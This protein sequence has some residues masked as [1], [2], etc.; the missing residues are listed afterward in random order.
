MPRLQRRSTGEDSLAEAID[1]LTRD[2]A[3]AATVEP[4]SDLSLPAARY[5]RKR[6]GDWPRSTRLA[7]VSEMASLGE[8]D[9]RF[10]FER[11]L[12]VALSDED[13]DVRLAAV[14]ALWE[15]E[16]TALLNEL[17][18]R[19][20]V[21]TETRVRRSLLRT[22]GRFARLAVEGRLD[23]DQRRRIEE[24]LVDAALRDS[25]EDIQLEAMVAVAYLQPVAI[26]SQIEDAYDQGHD[27][28]REQALRAMGRFGGQQWS[29]RV[30]DALRAGDSDQRVEAARAAPYVEDRRVVPYLYEAAED[31]E[32]PDIQF[33]ALRALGEIGGPEI[34]S[35]LEEM[36]DSTS[37]DVSQ[38]ADNALGNASLLDGT[39][40]GIPT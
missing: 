28:A 1:T 32:R 25:S 23:A 30:I 31:D 13:P 35:F 16:A 40:D 4:L 26:A 14:E 34:R 20:D 33:A 11:A 27:E 15:S 18:R 24:L 9:V 8:E 3:A 10:S 5:L 7:V 39:G 22:I 21:E 6:W 29:S 12:L 2:G 37:G 36:R 17:L 19:A 38:A